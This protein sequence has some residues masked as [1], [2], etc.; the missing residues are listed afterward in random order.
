MLQQRYFYFVLNLSNSLNDH[1]R[2]ID[3]IQRLDIVDSEVS[4][5]KAKLEILN[6]SKAFKREDTR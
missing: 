6:S 5:S 1:R 3:A 2:K 4:S